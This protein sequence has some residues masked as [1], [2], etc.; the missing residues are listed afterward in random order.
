MDT[1]YIFVYIHLISL[2]TGFGAVIA[3]DTF[4]L[5]WILGWFGVDLA[6]V[7]RAANVTQRLIWLGFIGLVCSG[8][9]MLYMK[10]H[11]DN[12]MWVKLFLVGMVG[13]N[14]VF[15]HFIKKQLEKLGEN[16][17]NVPKKIY[18]RIGLASGISQLGWWGATTIGY[19]HRQV[20]PFSSW[21]QQPILVI[22]IIIFI[23]GLVALVGEKIT[24]E[25]TVPPPTPGPGT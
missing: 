25:K 23:I 6:L 1:F 7:R 10:G 4:G 5:A 12:L 3:I 21:P 8:S 11:L 24:D 15:L 22:G 19:Y 16:I 13:L 2:I 14:G 17:T 9:V 20:V 18:F